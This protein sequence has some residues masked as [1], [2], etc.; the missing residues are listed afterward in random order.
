MPTEGHCIRCRRLNSH[1]VVGLGQVAFDSRVRYIEDG[2][3]GAELRD[4]VITD[5]EARKAWKRHRGE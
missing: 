5:V 2:L 1:A 3:R 4:A